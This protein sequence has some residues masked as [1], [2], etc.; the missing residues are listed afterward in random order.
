MISLPGY[1]VEML[2]TI[3]NAGCEAYAVGGSV[4]DA[5]LGKKPTDIDITTSATPEKIMG[6]F[7]RS[8]LTGGK[9]LTVTALH[10]GG[11]AEITPFRSESGYSD[12][13]RPDEVHVASGLEEDLKRRD[14]TV[15]TLCFDGER[16]IDLL[17]GIADI[18][19]KLI[20]C[21]GEPERRF[22]EDALRI[23]RAFRF[24][25]QLGFEIEPRT[26][27]A[28]L[29]LSPKL[30]E[31]SV[32]RVR[33]ELIKTA[34]SPAPER[35]SPLLECGALSFLKLS[36]SPLLPMVKNVGRDEIT[37]LAA[38]FYAC[39]REAVGLIKLPARLKRDIQGVFAVLDSLPP[40]EETAVKREMSRFSAGVFAAV[41]EIAEKLLGKTGRYSDICRTVVESGAPYR[42]SDLAVSG[43]D[44]KSAGV[45]DRQI[46]AV[47]QILLDAVI[48]DPRLNERDTLITL[49][50]KYAE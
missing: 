30:R 48:E 28:A 40:A 49:S 24:S 41:A 29:S 45:P 25:A 7:P 6:L 1:A 11:K 50:S 34:L 13:R 32:E 3:K 2:N 47:L 17:G 46:G 4:R 12:S 14:F 26:L 42:V 35:I 44:L 39:G 19:A 18:K 16:V 33:D 36:I 10:G 22:D 31:I 8:V 9:Y 27:S 43:G 37:R 38:F 20:R 5:V 21:V 15:N 23:M